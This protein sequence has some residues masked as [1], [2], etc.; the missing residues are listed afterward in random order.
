MYYKQ[1]L[2]SITLSRDK[3]IND[4]KKRWKHLFQIFRGDEKK[5]EDGGEGQVDSA[6]TRAT[7]KERT[8]PHFYY[9]SSFFF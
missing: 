1:K 3:S 6:W 2:R 8:L 9:Y 4:N 7:L 5:S